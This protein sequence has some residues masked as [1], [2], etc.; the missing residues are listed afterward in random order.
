MMSEEA[1]AEH[2]SREEEVGHFPPRAPRAT[3]RPAMR[4]GE[5]DELL[6]H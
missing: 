3:R 4:W 5:G 6:L 1:A 2:L